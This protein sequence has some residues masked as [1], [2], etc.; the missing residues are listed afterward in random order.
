MA[1][2]N[3]NLTNWHQ[4]SPEPQEF[5]FS[6]RT[7][8]WTPKIWGKLPLNERFTEKWMADHRHENCPPHQ[9]MRDY[10]TM[11]TDDFEDMRLWGQIPNSKILKNIGYMMP[12]LWEYMSF[13]GFLGALRTQ[14][15]EMYIF[16]H[17]LLFFENFL[18][19]LPKFVMFKIFVLKVACPQSRLSSKSHVLKVVSSTSQSSTSPVLNVP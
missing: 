15:W 6:T 9:S 5:K 13:G 1:G 11:R 8:Q 4:S 19:I 12:T 10:G 16:G 7:V 18:T 14:G 2:Q 17:F 3:R